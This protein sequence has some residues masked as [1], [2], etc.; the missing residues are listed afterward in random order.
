[1]VVTEHQICELSMYTLSGDIQCT[2]F[3]GTFDVH[4]FWGHYVHT[5]WGQPMYTL[6]GDI[7]CTHYLGTSNVHTFWGHSMYT[8]S[9]DIQCTH[10]LG[11]FIVHT[12]WG[13][14]VHTFWG[15]SMYQQL[16]LGYLSLTIASGIYMM[17][18]ISETFQ[19]SLKLIYI[20]RTSNDVLLL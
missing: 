4:T 6:S 7:Q 19:E 14:Y 18:C 3:L 5:F 8:L 2:H 1:M 10:F 13:H 17:H 9:G 20:E 16:A 11:T 15:H 12:F